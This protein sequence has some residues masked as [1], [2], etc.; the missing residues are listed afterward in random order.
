MIMWLAAKQ[1]EP[2]YWDS[3]PTVSFG[4]HRSSRKASVC[5][6]DPWRQALSGFG[7]LRTTCPC[8]QEESPSEKGLFTYVYWILG[9][10]LDH[11]CPSS[12]LC[13][14]SAWGYQRESSPTISQPM[15]AWCQLAIGHFLGRRRNV[16][17]KLTKDSVKSLI[18]KGTG[19]YQ[20]EVHVDI[21]TRQSQSGCFFLFRWWSFN[22]IGTNVW[23]SEIVFS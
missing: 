21:T 15:T 16:N 8:C 14:A 11:K 5:F 19:W 3:I 18:C 7:H 1:L 20:I 2:C 4:A 23:L 10:L 13:S 12:F 6:P 9:D 17:S 22:T